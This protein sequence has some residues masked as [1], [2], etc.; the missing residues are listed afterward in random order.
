MI[1]IFLKIG[2]TM[3]LLLI[4]SMPFLSEE[5]LDYIGNIINIF[6]NLMFFSAVIFVILWV[7]Y[8]IWTKL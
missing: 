4:L 1:I 3:L 6:R 2:L 8:A 7:F 5:N